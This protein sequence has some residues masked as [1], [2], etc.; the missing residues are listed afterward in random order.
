MLAAIIR[1]AIR[2]RIAVVLAVAGLAAI[3]IAKLPDARYGVFPEF[4]APTVLVETATPGLS[5]RETEQTVTDP[6]ERGF[7]GVPGLAVMRSTSQPGLS[8]I[9]LVFHGGTDP[10]TDR[11]LVTGRLAE[12]GGKLPP[13]MSPTLVPMQSAAGTVLGVGLHSDTLTLPQVTAIAQTEL[14]PAL[15]AVPGVANVVMYGAEP[16]QLE[17]DL[18]PAALIRSAFSL[19]NL[20][21]AAQLASGV[22]GGGFVDTGNQRLPLDIHGQA[23]T[24]KALAAALLGMR[25][26]VPVS[27]GDVAHVRITGPPRLGAALIRGRPGLLLMVS[28]L[29]G[30]NTLA[31]ADQAQRVLGRLAPA[32]RTQGVIVDRHAFEPSSFVREALRDLGQVLLVS[33]GLILLVLLL[34]LRDWRVALISFVSIPASLLAAVAVLTAAGMSLSTMALAGLAIALGEMVDD[35]VVDVENIGR[36]LRE[37]RAAGGPARPLAV[38]LRASLEVRGAIIFA[39]LCVVVAFTPVLALGGVAG[40][41][42]APLGLAYIA[43]I[44]ASLAVALTLTPA[45]CAVLLAHGRAMRDPPI[46]ALRARYRALLARSGRHGRATPLLVGGALLAAGIAAASLPFVQADF[47]PDFQENDVIIHN[48]AAPGTSLDTMLAIGRHTLDVLL[49]SKLVSHAVMHVG[50]AP[51]SD[52]HADVND[53]EFDVTLSRLG[54]RDP[55]ASNAALMGKV[56][57]LGGLAWWSNSFLTERI[58]E[59]LSGVTAPVT[60]SVFG[61]KLAAIDADARA[62]ARAIGIV[63]GVETAAVAAPPDVPALIVTLDRAAML[64]DGVDAATALQAVRT[65][66]A[67]TTVGRVYRG[68][69]VEKV[70]IAL[71]PALRHDP[72]AIATI[73][74]RAA[75]GRTFTL[76]QIARIHDGRAADEIM[77]QDGRREQDISVEVMPGAAGRAFAAIRHRIAGITLHEGDYVVYGGTV[78]AGNAARRSLLLHG[79]IALAAIIGLMAMAVGTARA[80]G[81]LLL[82]LP[83]A[84]AGGIAATWLF[85]GGHLSLGAMVGMVTLFGVTLR[86]GLLLLIHARRLVR[87]EGMVWSAET[88]RQ[89]AGDRLP[90]I[91]ITASVTALGLLPLAAANGTPGD[92]IEGPMAIVILGGLVTATLLSVFVLPNAAARF[93]R[94]GRDAEGDGLD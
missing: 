74:V 86:N 53:G 40:R 80:V 27:I 57:H 29:Y 26:G 79:V 71:A 70:V 15:R 1:A 68:M 61:P 42:F 2:F 62:I 39:T 83:A 50:S 55:A 46:A 44:L 41:L 64:R 11:S 10:L 87:E 8:A 25:D 30:T 45:L 5:A 28:S 56:G 84:L 78:I 33:A 88:A 20:A 82:L 94:F 52:D 13:G 93:V 16:P 90:A 37:N 3:Q 66:Y 23:R 76:G 75:D 22:R 32:L 69:L 89:A 51:L 17:I 38:I 91:L 43:A 48:L 24:T 58:E 59:S 7:T 77:H 63:P 6:L 67:G 35:A 18:T 49:H 72:R 19:G 65:A 92:A 12:V 47:L 4:V 85:L 73:P 36:R 21:Q 31:V 54:N 34:A 14:R 60:V 9:S 81:L